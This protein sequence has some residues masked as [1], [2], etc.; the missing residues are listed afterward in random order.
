MSSAVLLPRLPSTADRQPEEPLRWNRRL[1]KA[2]DV[3]REQFP[4]RSAEEAL[5]A[6][7]L[8]VEIKH[9]ERREVRIPSVRM[10]AF[11]TAVNDVL[12]NW[13]VDDVRNLNVRGEETPPTYD[14]VQLNSTT[15]QDF[16]VDGMRFL[17]QATAT[18]QRTSLRVEPAWYGLDITV[19]G[20][21]AT[22]TAEKLLAEITQRSRDIN[23]LKGEAF[24]L[25]G[26]FL[27]KTDETFADLFLDPKNA[28]AMARV[29]TLV[30]TRGKALENRGVLLMGPPGTG[31]TLAARIVRNEAKATF[32]WVSSRD[33]HYS[34]S[35]GGFSQ[36]FQI[37][38]ECA[39][40]VVVFEDIDNWLYDTTV[41]LIK[42]EMDGVAKSTGVVTMMT[43][44][45]PELLPAAL[46]DRPGRFHDVLKFD[47][48]DD[49]ART[50][51]LERWLPGLAPADLTR[52]VKALAGYS[53]AHVRELARF[54]KIIAEQ[55]ALSL[56]KALTE[57]LTKLAEQRDLIT[58]TQRTGSRYRMA[59][60][61]AQKSGT[62]TIQRAYSVLRI[63]SIDKTRRTVTGM[64]TTPE[65]DRVGDVIE[66]LGVTYKNPFPL[67]LYHDKTKPVG[68]TTFSRPTAEGVPFTAQLSTIDRPGIVKDRL[69]EAWDSLSADPPLITAVSIGFRELE[70]PTVI[71]ETGGYRFPKV[72]VVELSLVVI[73]ANQQATIHTIKSFDLAASGLHSPGVTG[74]PVVHALKDA[75]A[76]NTIAE[77]IT[78]FEN[79]RAAR[80]AAMV[81]VQA[82][83]EGRT[84]DEREREE[85]NNL[86][87]EIES[88]DLELVDLRKMEKIQLVKATAITARTPEQASEQRGGAPVITVKPNVEK[89]TAFTRYVLAKIN[90]KGSNADAIAYAE[91]NKQWMDQTPE[92]VLALK[93]AVNPG[94]T[95]EPS[96]A[97]PLAVAQPMKDEFLE[98]LRP[99]T[100]I[101][102]IPGLRRVPFNIS[103]PV[104][105]G[106]GT[107][108]WVGEGAP[109]PVGNLQFA[110]ATLLLAKAAGIIVI[111]QE[112][113]KVSSP[114]AEGAVRNDMIK[115]MAQYLDQQFIDPTVAA[116]ANVSPASITNAAVS[117]GSAGTSAANAETDF[118]GL[119]SSMITGNQGSVGTA[120]L[121]MSEVH[122]FVL[123]LART[124]NGERMFPN[125]GP[126]GGSIGGIPVITSQAAGTTVALVVPSEILF[127][128]DGGVD[129]DVSREASVEMDTAP[130]SP[131]A[132]GSVLVSLWQM[133]LIG[134]KAERFINWK[135]ARLNGV[136]YTTA[137]YV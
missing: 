108:R 16:L 61:V 8:E 47:L 106:G 6:K 52:A 43:T 28:A 96:W 135:R 89:G 55:D 2:F 93:A 136:R 113:A 37:A 109:K 99:A 103:M 73:P 91:N 29:V 66:P 1:S 58:A 71:R 59:P 92:V 75:P 131:V 83:A 85:F 65:P 87:R 27:P 134:L 34:G 41:D 35:F 25:S 42:T 4:A 67:L 51:M 130:T 17:R 121:I 81:A 19:Y 56:S 36:A 49:T 23:F 39:P 38:R 132:A 7:Y 5:V 137:T 98:L 44:N 111:S 62:S 68:Q 123:S 107:Y 133:N 70:Q 64:A 31:K 117:I 54:A 14:I 88:I 128:D 48:P 57:A 82:R 100:I 18:G 95:T 20:L 97:A 10:G 32:I 24:S 53:G 84:K 110:S 126:L 86:E 125:L 119:V 15:N 118:K 77:Q 45:Y 104:Q 90:G 114:S 9:L 3:A 40:S 78:S 26:E 120:V 63:K 50:S 74:L 60:E 122:A 129:I 13:S 127:A 11:L 80:A 33:F 30:N 105:T 69:D 72:E 46:I 124:T 76:M 102:K 21:R 101:G 22:G 94:T 112:L 12:K 115:G 116:V 79:T